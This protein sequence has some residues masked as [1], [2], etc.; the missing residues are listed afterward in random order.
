MKTTLVLVASILAVAL[1][2]LPASFD[3]RD[4]WPKCK[5]P[6]LNQGRCGSCWAFSATT[7]LSS[8]FCIESDGKISPDQVL[9]PQYLLNC[10]HDQGGCGGG[11]TL[12]A[13][14]FMK[15]TGIDLLSCT[16][17]TSGDSGQT[18]SSCPAKCKNGSS[19]KIF[20]GVDAYSLVKGST[21]ETV[22]AMKTEL[23]NHGPFSVSFVVYRDF[24][25][26][27]KKTP[28]GIYEAKSS[29][30]LGGH[31]VR[32]VGYGEESGKK[33]WLIAN[34]WGTEWGDNGYF[35]IAQGINTAT[36]E[37]RRVTA[38]RPKSNEFQAHSHHVSPVDN[39]VIDGGFNKVPVDAEILEIAKFSLSDMHNNG[40]P[41]DTFFG[42]EEAFTQ[43]TNGISYHLKLSV[44][45]P[46]EN[47]PSSV[48]VV[49]NRSPLDKL[50]VVSHNL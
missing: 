44:V 24:M 4:K 42:V 45:K 25:E 31:A 27:F 10:E 23:V 49:V 26:F 12:K 30:A 6:I 39:I 35:R 29:A 46:N 20:H 34:S 21:A 41:V 14:G 13:Y 5:I 43:V 17:Y 22:E 33:Y 1:A 15:S 9:S 19:I 8:R 50:S 37:S 7:A 32:V 40:T 48:N 28:K 38:G 3:A 2:A 11:D 16:P 36:I 47:G 18:E